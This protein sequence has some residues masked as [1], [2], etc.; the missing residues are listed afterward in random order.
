VFF[1]PGK[2]IDLAVPVDSHLDSNM[3]RSS[4]PVE[5]QALAGLY[6]AQAQG[7]VADNSSTEERCGFLI[8]EYFWNGIA[9]LLGD[10]YVLSVA[11]VYMIA[12]EAGGFTEVLIFP[13]AERA[14]TAGRI[15]PGNT[16]PVPFF[17]T[18]SVFPNLFHNSYNL[19][20]GDYRK[21]DLGKLPFY[22]MKVCMADTTDFEAKKDL[23]RVWFWDGKV[24][25]LKGILVNRCKSFQDH[26]FHWSTSSL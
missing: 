4:E 7:S 3:C 5:A 21:F 12:S 2:D 22:G 13:L 15:E 9:K 1:A 20:T 16:E 10:D 11:A 17:K 6:L 24:N 23:F 25:K 8:R 14:L 19:M 18:R 26:C